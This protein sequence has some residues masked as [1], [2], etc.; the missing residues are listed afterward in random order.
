MDDP[1][2]WVLQRRAGNP[3]T[4]NSGWENRSFCTTREALLRCVRK[5]CGES[6]QLRSMRSAAFPNIAATLKPITA[7]KCEFW[8]L[9]K[10]DYGLT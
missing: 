6:T 2:Q 3:R 7:L 9:E 1:L 4:K 8:A 10:T 5:Y